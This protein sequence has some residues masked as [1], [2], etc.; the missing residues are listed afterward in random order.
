MPSEYIRPCASG[1]I[2]NEAKDGCDPAC[3][4]TEHSD[5]EN[6]DSEY[7]NCKV[8][9]AGDGCEDDNAIFTS[10]GILKPASGGRSSTGLCVPCGMYE[11]YLNNVKGTDGMP[12]EFSFGRSA[13]FK[14]MLD[15]PDAKV[16]IDTTREDGQPVFNHVV[17]FHLPCA[18]QGAEIRNGIYK[19]NIASRN[20][21]ALST[22]DGR[23]N[24][25][26]HVKDTT[27]KANQATDGKGGALHLSGANSGA[28]LD[29]VVFDS[30]YAGL[31]GGGISVDK[32]AALRMK[33]S[34]AFKNYVRPMRKYIDENGKSKVA[35][36]G[37]S[38]GFLHALYGGP[39]M[40][41]QDTRL[42]NNTSG[43]RG[44]AMHVESTTMALH[45]ID[46]FHNVAGEKGGGLS[47]LNGAEIHMSQSK[48]KNN[49]ARTSGGGD[50]YV[51]SSKFIFHGVGSKLVWP[52][53]RPIFHENLDLV[54]NS[55]T[56]LTGGVA[57]HG[58]SIAAVAS[59]GFE[60][61]R[62][63]AVAEDKVED[64][65]NKIDQLKCLSTLY[66]YEIKVDE[67]TGETPSKYLCVNNG[68]YLGDGTII[69][70]ATATGDGGGGAVHAAMTIVSLAGATIGK[71]S[72]LLS[73]L[74]L[75]IL[76]NKQKRTLTF[77]F[78]FLYFHFHTWC[79]GVFI[80]SSTFFSSL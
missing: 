45:N 12:D 54:A 77:F 63:F 58:G 26:F 1:G 31:G 74:Y 79:F 44:G 3:S 40:L 41:I 14:L 72:F 51:S 61:A 56:T 48:A 33:N 5:C 22:A 18:Y 39:F 29:N 24:S 52:A 75:V 36:Y 25:L 17:K 9:D 16:L 47:V 67:A 76:Y 34:D 66:K 11:F 62:V 60:E 21:G 73:L 6:N 59:M 69:S 49:Q 80:F 32:G 7:H 20:G 8:N 19:S 50:V 71:F 37:S 78:F 38:G 57:Q 15:R 42:R 64:G 2:L 23:K 68:I 35:D 4:P 10:A 55:G 30:N 65:E 28:K 70:K 46:L 27:F 13:V 53:M 43:K